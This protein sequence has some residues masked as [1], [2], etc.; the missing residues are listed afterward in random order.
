MTEEVRISPEWCDAIRSWAAAIPSVDRVSLYGSRARGS[1]GPDSDLDLAV[2]V[3]APDGEHLSEWIENRQ[4]RQRWQQALN[5]RLG[6]KVHL[7][8]ANE[9]AEYVVAPAVAREGITIFQRQDGSNR[10]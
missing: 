7:E 8:F 10:R 1:P 9:E 5:A 2:Y 3:R 6:I 4:N